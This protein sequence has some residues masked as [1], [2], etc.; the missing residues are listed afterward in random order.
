MAL[1][2]SPARGCLKDPDSDQAVVLAASGP[3]G[4]ETARPAQPAF[5][6]NAKPQHTA[7][8][9]DDSILGVW[10]QALGTGPSVDLPR[11]NNVSAEPVE[12]PAWQLNLT[13]TG[14]LHDLLRRRLGSRPTARSAP[15]A[16]NQWPLDRQYGADP[17]SA[18]R[19]RVASAA[20]VAVGNSRASTSALNFVA[21]ERGFERAVEHARRPW[22]SIPRHYRTGGRA[23]PDHSCG[24]PSGNQSP[25]PGQPRERA[26]ATMCGNWPNP[27]PPRREKSVT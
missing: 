5:H 11:C 1:T 6:P 14:D 23:A 15:G 24:C 20:M 21:G 3:R 2:R 7:A 19:S 12:M 13:R 18:C 26:T 16:L 22:A 25:I 8:S 4:P 10:R 9:L 17:I 27:G